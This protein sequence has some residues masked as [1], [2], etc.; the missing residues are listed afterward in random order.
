MKPNEVIVGLLVR[1]STVLAVGNIFY[2]RCIVLEA[3]K[4]RVARSSCAHLNKGVIT[5]FDRKM[6]GRHFID[7]KNDRKMTEKGT[8]F[9]V[10][11]YF[12]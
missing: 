5:F 4:F 8:F 12:S 11:K 7:R 6:M 1:S 10:G 9:L 3:G 2:S